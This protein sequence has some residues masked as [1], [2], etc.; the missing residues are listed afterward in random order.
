MTELSDVFVL[1]PCF[2]PWCKPVTGPA[3]WSGGDGYHV[4]CTDCGIETYNFDTEAEAIAA[5]NTRA[6]RDAERMRE[7]LGRI[8]SCDLLEV[9]RYYERTRCIPETGNEYTSREPIF[10]RSSHQNAEEFQAIARQALGETH[11]N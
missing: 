10:K 4:G 2:V 11:D 7:A 9:E 6:L 1:K 3:L 8:A 5:W